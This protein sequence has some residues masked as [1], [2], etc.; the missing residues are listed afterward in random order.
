MCQLVHRPRTHHAYY[1]DYEFRL[2]FM[3]FDFE[4]VAL[5]QGRYSQ[6]AKAVPAKWSM[7]AAVVFRLCLTY[8]RGSSA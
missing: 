8:A 3:R 7:L 4:S 1:W 6:E 5:G 2:G